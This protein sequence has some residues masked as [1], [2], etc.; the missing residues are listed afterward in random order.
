MFVRGSTGIP[1]SMFTENSRKMGRRKI[2]EC[3]RRA[4][5]ERRTSVMVGGILRIQCLNWQRRDIT[6]AARY[7][8]S[9]DHLHTPGVSNRVVRVQNMPPVKYSAVE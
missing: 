5:R 1:S 3:W 6:H 4:H 8:T 7:R 9:S 2:I